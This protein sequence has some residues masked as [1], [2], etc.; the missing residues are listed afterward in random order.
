MIMKFRC[1]GIHRTRQFGGVKVMELNH[2]LI[3]AE[4]AEG[5]ARL[6]R[7]RRGERFPAARPT[8]HSARIRALPLM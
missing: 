5:I 2:R 6:L 8:C 1:Q 3:F 4:F 7:A